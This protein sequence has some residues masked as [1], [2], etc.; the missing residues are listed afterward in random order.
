MQRFMQAR[1]RFLFLARAAACAIVAASA[2]ACVK[3]PRRAP[4]AAA[5]EVT[6]VTNGAQVSPPA[7]DG[8]SD[9]P[10]LNLN[11]ATARELERLPGVG[12]ALA[13]RILE[14]RARYGPFRR[15][16]HL[17]AVRGVG[18]RRFRKLRPHLTVD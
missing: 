7:D 10:R 13:S 14:H 5:A 11:T 3:L 8:R 16:E 1:V 17:L 6:A 2:P 15:V 4:V 18:E 12:P 9:A